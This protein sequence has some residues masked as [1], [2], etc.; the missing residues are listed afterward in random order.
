ML[1]DYKL[2][3]IKCKLLIV[4]RNNETLIGRDVMTEFNIGVHNLNNIKN[5]KL[6]LDNLLDKFKDIFIII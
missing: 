3:K 1:I 6:E 5:T 2:V 4:Y